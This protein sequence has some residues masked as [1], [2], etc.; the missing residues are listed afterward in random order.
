VDAKLAR[1]KPFTFGDPAQLR[2]NGPDPFTSG[3]WVED[4]DKVKAYGRSDSSV[5]TPEQTDVAYFWSEHGYVHWNPN[6]IGLALAR[7]L[8]VLETARLFAMAYTAA[9]DAVIAGVEAKYF[10]RTWRPRTAIPRATEDGNPRTVPDP[11]WTPLLTVNHPEY[12]SGHALLSTAL[13]EAVAEFFGTDDV[14]WTIVTSKDAVP[15]L[16]QTKRTYRASTRSWT[17]SM[18]LGSGQACTTGTRWTRALRSAARSPG[19]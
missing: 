5:R 14:E 12:P 9:S 7:D 13:T 4:F 2:P 16:V 15:Q 18:T 6:L 11:T 8:D 1:V 17:M 3:R 19:T 10:Y